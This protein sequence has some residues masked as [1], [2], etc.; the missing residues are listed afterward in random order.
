[1]R[2]K[3]QLTLHTVFENLDNVT[4]FFVLGKS[5]D[6]PTGEDKTLLMFTVDHRQPGAL[7]DGL[8]VFKDYSINLT[9]ID[10]RPSAQR[11]W[12][13]MFFVEF[14]GHYG[15]EHVAKALKDLQSFCLDIVVLGSYPNQK[16][17]TL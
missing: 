2:I 5:S 10:S 3:L 13:Y 12:H 14:S 7:C 16:P 1:M 8:K 11:S 15:D 4:R 17:T 6:K 9:R